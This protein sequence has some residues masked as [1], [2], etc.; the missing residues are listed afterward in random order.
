MKKHWYDYLWI[1]S[2]IY[3]VLGFV[4]ILFA[5]D[6]PDLLCPPTLVCHHRREQRVL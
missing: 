2:L 4:H 1:F 5:W 3:L 6:W